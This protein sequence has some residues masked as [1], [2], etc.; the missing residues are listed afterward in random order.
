AI[1]QIPTEDNEPVKSVPLAMQ[2]LFYQLQISDTPVITTEL[3]N[4]FGW[5]S[6]VCNTQHDVQ[7]FDRV[8]LDYIENKMK[9]TNVDDA[10]S[11]LFV[12]KMK[13]Y[14]RCVNVNFE[15]SCIE[16]YYDILLEVKGHKTLS[17]SFMN[18]IREESCEYQTETYGLQD[19]KKGVI[20]ES[21]PP[22][23]RIQLNRF[24]YDSQKDT[25]V[26]INDR[27]EYPLEIDLE[28]YLSSD[29]DRSKPHNYLLH[30]VIVHSGDLYEGSYYIFLKPEKNGKWFKFDN[31]RIIPVIDKEVLGDNYE[32]EIT[33]ANSSMNAYMLIYIRES[34]IDF[35]LSPILAEDIPRH[36]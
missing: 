19:A 16:D 5:D 3:T 29:S 8:L 12:G 36:L 28:R 32:V 33:K 13:S 22:V 31:H 35:V 2:R 7:E 1:Y 14:V 6:S 26:K 30:G 9:N 11:R 17:D 4:S 27:L 20:F 18:Y 34:D 15:R 10:I 25:V 21:F 23:L 24:E